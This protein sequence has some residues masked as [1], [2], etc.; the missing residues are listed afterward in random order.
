MLAGRSSHSRLTAGDM[1][2]SHSSV[3]PTA[4][5][6]SKPGSD[7]ITKPLAL[8]RCALFTDLRSSP[9]VKTQTAFAWPGFTRP[10]SPRVPA[11]PL[12]V[13]FQHV[14]AFLCWAHQL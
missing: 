7:A 13:C 4:T 11:C 8:G 5:K 3:A 1:E 6:T 10:S 2:P 14:G 9:Q 12:P